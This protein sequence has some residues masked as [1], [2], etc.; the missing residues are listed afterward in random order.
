MATY[1]TQSQMETMEKSLEQI[2]DFISKSGQKP[3]LSTEV[4]SCLY[5]SA[6][7]F[8][9]HGKYET[10]QHFFQMLT[11]LEPHSKKN[12]MGLGATL[13]VQK[14][15]QLALEAYSFAALLDLNDPYISFHAAECFFFLDQIQH[16]FD[17]LTAAEE[18]AT[19]QKNDSPP[20]PLLNHI[21]LMRTGW[22]KYLKQT[23]DQHACTKT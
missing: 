18:I 8:Y 4:L 21:E 15:Y 16:G 9:T 17:A 14:N 23:G 20:H 11:V 3:I 5:A 13:Q 2:S 12:W 7:E 6:Y 19:Q 10:A 22:K 1:G